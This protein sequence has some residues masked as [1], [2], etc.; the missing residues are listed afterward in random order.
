MEQLQ[1]GYIFDCVRET[2]ENNY[3]A[4]EIKGLLVQLSCFDVDVYSYKKQIDNS[5]F[6]PF[7]FVLHNMF[8]RGLPTR[9]SLELE[10]KILNAFNITKIDENLLEI[11]SI[12]QELK[13]DKT[14][15]EKLFRALYIID[16]EINENNIKQQKLDSDFEEDFLYRKLPK[17]A[18]HVWM[19]LLEK[20]RYLPDI[21]K[22]GKENLAHGFIEQRVDF[23]IEFPYKIN[24]IKG[25]VVEIDGSQHQ[26]KGQEYQDK[27][28]DEALKKAG[29]GKTLRIKT[30]EWENIEKKIKDV[31]KRSEE[32]FTFFSEIKQNFENP[33]YNEKEGLTA[34]EFILIPFAV[35]RIEQ[36]IVHL[37]LKNELDINAE[38]WDIAIIER[39]IP[40]GRLAIEDF[41]NL[42]NSLLKL[43]LKDTKLPQINLFIQSDKRFSKANF[44]TKSNLDKNKKYDLLIDISILQRS[45]LTD[46]EQ[47]VE[48]DTKVLI[49]SVHSQKVERKFKTTELINYKPLGVKNLQKDK[50]EQYN[51]QTQVLEKFLQ[52]FFR[53]KSFREGQIEILNIALQTLDVIG[54]LP[55]GSGK[56]L[57]YQLAG[58]LQPGIT[59]VIDPLKSLMTDQKDGLLKNAIDGVNYINSTLD[60]KE[61]EIELKRIEKGEVLFTFVSPERLQIE[62]F[63]DSV[64]DFNDNG[65]Y[66]SY[67]VIDEAHCVSEWGHDFR[68]SYL[69]LGENARNHCKAKNR[70]HLPFFA[71]TAT[72]SYDVLSDIQR[73]L[74]ITEETSIVRMEQLDRPEIQFKIVEVVT[75]KLSLNKMPNHKDNRK[76]VGKIKQEE[77]FRLF[78]KIPQYFSEFNSDNTIEERIKLSNFNDS[79][80]YTQKGRESNAGIVFFP[81]TR[82]FFGPNDKDGSLAYLEEHLDPIKN[83][84]ETSYSLEQIREI[85]IGVFVG[86]N[87]EDEDKEK[88]KKQDDEN[89]Q[90]QKDFIS[91][92]LNLLLATKAF[93][94]GIDKSNIRYVVHFN[95]PSSIESYYQEVGRAGRDRKLAL[96]IILFNKQELNY[97]ENIE[98]I[99]EEG[100]IERSLDEAKASVDRYILLNFQ[101]NNFKGIKK[102]KIILLSYP[103]VFCIFVA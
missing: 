101:K 30:K 22:N 73:E 12:R 26:E 54:L 96:G 39:D 45:E 65:N 62:K 75:N 8:V 34:L 63:R 5:V 9:P 94:M 72:A 59:I 50:F 76:E 44:Y 29:W 42:F 85:N 74:K 88:S 28:R 11:G 89:I 95:Y 55:T 17:F 33:L 32:D 70:E 18:S 53:K 82:W 31:F 4:E 49:R 91:N 103:F 7:L 84:T 27:Q 71:L 43:K 1:A 98:K 90:T 67:C 57:T 83:K 38:H 51:E 80:F 66:F 61:K 40:C 46:I 47:E 14:F 24:N 21:L 97:K 99:G 56:S 93:G 10:N 36:T 16:P 48:A 19:Q 3:K 100:K 64:Y 58:L 92:K 79:E 35:A 37:L 77:L 69:R 13:V 23:S 86:S 52:D 15:I 81:H 60:E 25:F 2:L 87:N 68:T 78:T 102:E 20:Q 41:T 6:E